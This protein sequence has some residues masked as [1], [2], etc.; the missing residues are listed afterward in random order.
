MPR[1]AAVAAN[2]HGKA[3][4]QQGRRDAAGSVRARGGNS[5]PAAV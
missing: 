3:L 4:V 2:A 5:L 1:Q